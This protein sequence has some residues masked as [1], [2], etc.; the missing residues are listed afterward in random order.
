MHLRAHT[1]MGHVVYSCR[2]DAPF[3]IRDVHAIP[4]EGPWPDYV[5][6]YFEDSRGKRYKLAVETYHGFGGS[7]AP[8]AA[9][10]AR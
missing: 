3:A 1:L 7:W 4:D 9:G 2:R 5:E 8:D 6:V 10:G